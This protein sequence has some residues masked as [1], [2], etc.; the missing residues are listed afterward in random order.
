M[1]CAVEMIFSGIS[2]KERHLKVATSV[3]IIACEVLH[4]AVRWKILHFYVVIKRFYVVF[5]I[6]DC[7]L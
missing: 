7:M 2:C 4:I 1:F 5:L 3:P 6:I